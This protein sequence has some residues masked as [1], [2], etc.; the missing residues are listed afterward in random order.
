MII[1]QNAYQK[2]LHKDSGIHPEFFYE[3]NN[4]YS[5]QQ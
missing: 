2:H 1:K 5:K 3:R 4:P